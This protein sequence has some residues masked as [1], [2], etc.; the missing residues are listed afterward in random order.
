MC[1]APP[2]QRRGPAQRAI[3]TGDPTIDTQDAVALLL[4][5]AAAGYAIRTLLRKWRGQG[6]GCGKTACPAQT[7]AQPPTRTLYRLPV[8]DATPTP[9]SQTHPASPKTPVA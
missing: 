7:R 4:V 1:F 5:A 6:C 3:L 8:F 9:N 2:G